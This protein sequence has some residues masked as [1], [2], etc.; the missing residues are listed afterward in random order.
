MGVGCDTEMG[1]AGGGAVAG[2]FAGGDT[3]M[4]DVLTVEL[5]EGEPNLLTH[6]TKH[7]S[8]P[9]PQQHAKIQLAA[10]NAGI[11]NANMIHGW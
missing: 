3:N 9:Q 10:S 2:S 4:L 1:I 5:V 6:K 8:D 11:S 7:P